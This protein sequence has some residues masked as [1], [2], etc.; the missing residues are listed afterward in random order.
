MIP[1]YQIGQKV[2]LR[3]ADQTA[4]LR[5]STLEQ[6]VGKIGQITNYYWISP[7]AGEIFYIYSVR[8]PEFNKEIV[9]HE[10]EIKSFIESKGAFHRNK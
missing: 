4:S 2:T 6:Y 8:F 10:D 5:D 3:V 9:L 7:M 1:K